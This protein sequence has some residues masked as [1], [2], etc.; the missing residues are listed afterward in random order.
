MRRDRGPRRSSPV[1]LDP[2]R[3]RAARI[4]LRWMEGPATAEALVR[5]HEE[6]R[7][8]QERPLSEGDR[9]RLRE[10]VFGTVRLKGRYD[11]LVGR[12]ARRRPDPPVRVA[13]W[14]AC[15]EILELSTPDHA[16]VSQ[17]VALVRDLGAASAAGYVNGILRR[18]LREGAEGHF[19]D[20][21][22]EPGFAHCRFPLLSPRR[23]AV[24]RA[25][26]SP[27]R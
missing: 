27:R 2:V 12:L 20:P 17:A 22:R 5:G 1:A 19:P 3:R 21:G 7:H 18:L 16:A 13:L 23:L 4:L 15:H 26:Q 10:L 9:R 14:L 25:G 6:Q 24:L 11:H 8:R